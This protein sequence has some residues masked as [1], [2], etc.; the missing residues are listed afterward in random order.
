MWTSRTANVT[1]SHATTNR[2]HMP[3][4]VA[5]TLLSFVIAM[6]PAGPGSS[7]L[8]QTTS[9]EE[10][11][12]KKAR[13]IHEKVIT[14]DTHIDFSPGDL[15]GERNYT[16]R[17]ETQFN[18]PNMIDG[19]LNALFFSI[20]VGQTREAQNPDAFKPAGYERAYQ[21]AVEK[22]D[23]VRRFTREIAPDKIEV[24]LNAAD[25][26]RITGQGKKAALMGVEN[27][28]PIGED[29]ARVKEFY[30]RGARYLSLT[31]NG[32]N[33]LADSQTGERDGWK[34]NG[35]SP[36]GKQVIAEMNRLGIMVDISHASK[37]SMMQTAALSKAPIIASHSAARAL[38]DVSRNMDDE[39]LLALKKTGGVI[40]VVAYSSFVKT[41]T[42]DSADRATALAALRKEYNLPEPTG[43]GQRARFQAK[44]TQLS[45]DNRAEYDKKL[46]EIDKQHPGDPPATIKDFVDHIDYAVK[47]IG[48]DHVGISSDFDGG[49][50]VIG[51]N[52]ASETFN[53]TLELVRRGYTEQQIE[54]LWGGNLLRVMDDVQRIAEELRKSRSG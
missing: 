19:G 41:T 16:Q 24:A 38:C 43:P 22:F 33:Q 15:V 29:I 48:I 18:L 53:V 30:D 37:E 49:G 42:P 50:G 7:T 26:R 3:R 31:H 5:F 10:A 27:G 51:W 9:A 54:K 45:V 23:A 11:V 28:Y 8:A 17:L 44:L 12:V 52:D 1:V 47:L 21:L 36:L 32:H 46:A 34:W 13:A 6:S 2:L 4:H 40:Q 14:L 25:V 20:Y 35:L 39:Q